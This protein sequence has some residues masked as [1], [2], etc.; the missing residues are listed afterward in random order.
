[1]ATPPTEDS[2]RAIRAVVDKSV[3]NILWSAFAFFSTK[4]LNLL[5]VLILAR[6]LTPAEFGLV[7]L[8]LVVV[9]YCEIFARFG[10]SAAVI[11]APGDPDEAAGAAFWMALAFSTGMAALLW[12]GSPWI[13]V[14]FA[15]PLLEPLLGLLALALVVEASSVVHAGL[16]QRKLRFKAKVYPDV[17]RGLVKGGVS[18]ALAFMGWGVWSMVIGHLAGALAFTL[19][20]WLIEPWAPWK[21]L[22]RSA[23]ASMFRY[24]GALIGAELIGGAQRALPQLLIGKLLGPGPTGLFTMAQ[25]LPDLTVKSLGYVA[26]GVAH[27]VMAQ[28]QA[29]PAHMKRYFRGCVRYFGIIM[30]PCSVVLALS[31]QPLT[32]ILFDP[33]WA[34]M[35]RTMEILSIAFGFSAIGLLPGS[36]Y[37]AINRTDRLFIVSLVTLPIFAGALWVGA[38][39]G[40]EGVALGQLAA[41]ILAFAPNLY[42]LHRN[43]DV[44]PLE[45]LTALGPGLAISAMIGL[46]GFGVRASLTQYASG[47]VPML[48]LVVLLIVCGLVGMAG[49]RFLSPETL[50]EL[51]RM[52]AGR[53]RKRPATTPT[54]AE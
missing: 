6:L 31:A 14:Y 29:D 24:G 52:I 41:S 33:R 32:E 39:H 27:P 7:A 4:G 1:M 34:D 42:F 13:A 36:A 50:V 3:I 21:R 20:L 51:R 11:S 28:M 19:L 26:S 30:L 38:Q 5:T 18:I 9:A 22:Q 12:A 35:A 37:K 16:L 8:C 54:P 43:L 48:D 25:K 2:K 49:L 47:S 10:L 17:G 40:I 15:E 46:S 44:S 45:F 53:F 23:F